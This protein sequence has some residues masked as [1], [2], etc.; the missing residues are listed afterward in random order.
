MVAKETSRIERHFAVD[1]NGWPQAIHTTTANV[2]ERDGEETL[3]ALNSKQFR[4]VKSV[5][6]DSGYTGDNFAGLAQSTISAET[7]IAKQSDLK[8]G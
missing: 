5:M 6:T 7:I 1:I 2:S 4:L 8:N 3:L